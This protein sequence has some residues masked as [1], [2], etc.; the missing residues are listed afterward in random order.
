MRIA[1]NQPRQF[2]PNLD[3]ILPGKIVC[4]RPVYNPAYRLFTSAYFSAYFAAYF[5][6][7]GR[8]RRHG[9]TQ[10]RLILRLE[11]IT[12]LRASCRLFQN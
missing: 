12:P 3:Q 2:P 4:K 6:L 10:I 7:L 1:Q 11:K 9:L 5:P 8:A